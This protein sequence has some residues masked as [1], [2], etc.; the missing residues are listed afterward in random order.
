MERLLNLKSASNRPILNESLRYL[1]RAVSCPED[2]QE[3]VSVIVKVD[4][5][6]GKVTASVSVD[7]DV[8]DI[9]AEF[10]ERLERP[11]SEIEC[12]IKEVC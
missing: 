1:T 9:L 5:F 6:L 12:R 2:R 3:N 10:N 11:R 7:N 4:D 8:W